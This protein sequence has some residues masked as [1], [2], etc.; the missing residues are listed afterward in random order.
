MEKT[1]FAV[2]IL[3][4]GRPDNVVTYDTLKRQNYTGKIYII[5][6]NEDKSANEYYKQFGKENV[7]MF[8]KKAIS[9]K[10]DGFDN[11]NDRRTIVYARNACFDIAE[12]LGIKYFLQLDDDYTAFDFRVFLDG[13]GYTKP[14]KNLDILFK[15][16]LSY[17]K[18]INVMSIAYAQGGDFM[19][20]LHLYPNIGISARFLYGAISNA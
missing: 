6:D 7:I 20:V 3:T 15:N 16:T 8:D 17:F 9:K 1:N 5:I 2:F 13:K 19:N 14:T 4:H 10:F 11:F 12:D 18:D